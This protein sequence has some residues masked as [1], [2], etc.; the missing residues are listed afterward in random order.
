MYKLS[1]YVVTPGL[2]QCRIE[3]YKKKIFSL[4]T[5]IYQLRFFLLGRRD[6]IRFVL[7]CLFLLMECINTLPRSGSVFWLDV[8]SAKYRSKEFS[9]FQLVFFIVFFKLCLFRFGLSS[10]AKGNNQLPSSWRGG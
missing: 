7:W 8:F 5:S 4:P 3:N 10:L 1:L 6:N 9:L 2:I